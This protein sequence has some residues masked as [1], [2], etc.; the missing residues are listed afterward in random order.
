MW[1]VGRERRWFLYPPSAVGLAFGLLAFAAA[2][3]PSMLP[4]AA[5]VQGVLAGVAMAA[6][7]LVGVFL[8]WL[9]SYLELP[10][11]DR[12]AERPMGG[13]PGLLTVAA[14]ALVAGVALWRSVEW[15]NTLRA[16]MEMPAVDL[17]YPLGVT[18][19]A[20]P[21]FALLLAVGRLFRLT[22]FAVQAR[23]AW[24]VP[25]RVANVIAVAIAVL[26]FA[27][28]SDG[29]L[30]KTGLRAFDASYARLD[31]LIDP[32][33]EPPADASKVGSA[34][35]L[36]DWRSL[37]R[38]GR[39]YI[40]GGPGRG[41]I[42]AFTGDEAMEPIR[43]Y[44]GLGSAE[45]VEDRAR[46]ALDELI[47]V[48][49]FERSLLIVAAPT[50]TGWLDPAAMNSLEYLAHGDVATVAM[51]YSYLASWLSLLFEP[52]YGAEAAHALYKAVHD[53]WS[54]MPRDRRPKLVLHGLSLG[55]LSSQQAIRLFDLMS[56][57]IAGAMW[58]GP[59]FPSQHWRNATDAR[60][61]D[62]P[63]WLPRLGDGSMVR[64]TSQRNALGDATAD[65]G[66]VRFVYLQYA[67]DP[68]TFFEPS[69]AYREPAWMTG[70][71]GPD[72][73]PGLRWFPFV[74]FLQLGVDVMIATTT[75][76]GY[77][78]VYAPEHYLDAW[79][80]VLGAGDWTPAEIDRLKR[81][82]RG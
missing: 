70:E 22:F 6:G 8:V 58:A 34:A 67:S 14:T 19:L 46:L 10:G 76:M 81:H 82:L 64:F 31:Q 56:N 24:A 55:A 77:G 3:T 18:L 12:S 36:V 49:G 73:S 45:T 62:S 47:R 72:V 65:W 4:R 16:L 33:T 38:A 9:W 57:P 66:P 21:V 71:R 75:P 52:G 17:A 48:G 54:A 13:A 27:L 59:P 60:N 68:I 78:H 74:T 26:L 28:V 50:G 15:Q 1:L 30:F 7:Y 51:Q 53:H 32:D 35:S 79:M 39:E 44:V 43:V 5:L 63:A 25:R 69:S 42:E 40:S 29:L 61:P 2:L 41:D 11:A 80:G 23:I 37:G 20:L